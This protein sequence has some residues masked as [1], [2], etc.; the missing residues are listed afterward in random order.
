M[1]SNKKKEDLKKKMEALNLFEKD[2]LEKFILASKK[3]GQKVQKTKSCVYLKHIP[4]KIE[5][6]CQK[7]RDRETNRYLARKM[8]LEIFQKKFLKIKTK[9]EKIKEKNKKQKK[10]RKRKSLKK[11]IKNLDKSS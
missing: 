2:F 11:Y 3:G 1:I 4:T 7:E 5:V 10:R 9:K 6:K 8:V